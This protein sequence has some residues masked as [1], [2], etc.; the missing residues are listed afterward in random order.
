MQQSPR[1]RTVAILRGHHLIDLHLCNCG[2]EFTT[3]RGPDEW[4]EHTANVLMRGS[5]K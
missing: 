5:Y 4:A 1:V 3:G 2:E